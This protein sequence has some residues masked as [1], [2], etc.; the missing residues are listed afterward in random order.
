[1]DIGAILNIRG[2]DGRTALEQALEYNCS[3]IAEVLINAD[4]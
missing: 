3:E 2:G 4:D 1:M